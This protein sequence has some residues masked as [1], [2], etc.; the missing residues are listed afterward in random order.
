MWTK[1]LIALFALDL[2][3]QVNGQQWCIAT[4]CFLQLGQCVLDSQCYKVLTC[5]QECADAPDQAGCAFGCGMLDGNEHFRNLLK[6]M[7]END[8]M[9]KYDDDGLCLATN[10]QALQSITDIEQVKGDWWVLKGRNCGQDDVWPG[11]YDWYP[12]QHARF[13]KVDEGYWINNT[14]YC[15]GKDST[16]TSDTIVTIPRLELIAPGV[17][18]H[19]YPEGEAPIVPQVEDWKFV[20]IPDPDWALVIWCGSN[21]VLK[22]NGAFV[23]SRHRSLNELTEDI[24]LQLMEATEKFGIDYGAMCVSDNTKCEE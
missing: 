11:G 14:T 15:N 7:V 22:Y 2:L 8:C 19:D 17:V 1:A 5:L 9:V 12:C 3:H 18:R 10:D 13:A 24:E 16:C 23:I 4:H 20:A 6:C 21:P